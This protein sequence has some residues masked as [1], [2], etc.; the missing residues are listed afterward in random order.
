MF[1]I[2][3]KAQ[4][5]PGASANLQTAPAGSYVIAMD[6]VNQAASLI[7]PSSGTYL[8]NLKAYCL[9]V[10]LLDVNYKLRWVIKPGK[11][12]YSEIKKIV[13]AKRDS[14][15]HIF[16]N[17]AIDKVQIMVDAKE[18]EKLLV[19][20]Y[21]ISGHLAGQVLTTIKNQQAQLNIRQL[22]SGPYLVIGSTLS[23]DSYKTKLTIK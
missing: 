11:T 20:F 18:G 3:S 6:N 23:G 12:I 9:A 5:I 19:E 2:V 15:L 13:F 7:N 21:D 1:V 16:P 22:P 10:W 8:F 17:P 4:D 14:S